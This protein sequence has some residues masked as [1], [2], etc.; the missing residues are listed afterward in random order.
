MVLENLKPKLVWEI[1]EE[2]IA[3][4]P[5]PS[6]HEEQLR[7]AI[8]NWVQGQAKAN[9][10]DIR[11]K[12]DAV[13]NIFIKLPASRGMES[14]P[15]ILFQA[16]LDMV[17]VTD[18][19]G[20]F[21]FDTNPIP[22]R[23]QDNNE[24]VDADG[25]SLGADNGIGVALALAL[26]FEVN[27][28]MKHGPI[29]VL[30]TVDEEAGMSGVRELDVEALEIESKLL[31]NNDTDC[32]GEIYIGCSGGSETTFTKKLERIKDFSEQDYKFVEISISGLLGGHSG[33]E[34]HLPRANA[35]KLMARCLSAGNET[36]DLCL[37]EWNGG[38]KMN[39]IPRVAK[40][41]IAVPADNFGAFQRTFNSEVELIMNYWQYPSEHVEKLEPSLKIELKD[42]KSEPFFYKDETKAIIST[43][44]MVFNGVVNFSPTIEGLTE[45]SNNF[46]IV[47]TTENEIS[48]HFYSRGNHDLK[49]FI[50]SLV[51]LG[52]YTNWE[53]V[54]HEVN[55]GW[56]PDFDSPFLKFVKEHYEKVYQKP[57]IVTAI[58]GGL[59][60]REFIKKIPG[61]QMVSFGPTILRLHSPD[62]KLRIAD[63]GIIFRVI[64]E[65]VTNIDK[66]K[67][68]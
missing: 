42:A 46:A 31:V 12:E 22:I 24:W 16:H 43:A 20:G 48:F 13:G 5:H 29:E 51:Q 40:A 8:K 36:T 18:R 58:H 49:A 59:E 11:M 10:L 26:L 19:P 34:I 3:K 57:I 9:G 67:S 33:G 21:N 25:T 44:D 37:C 64:K 66:Y 45:T 56:I 6:K 50:R 27:G 39:A 2:L 61:I 38:D 30:L 55:F 14:S 35:N 62:E 32:L 68:K 23:I 1:F 53:I 28:D 7:D 52:K 54:K 17:C 63:V 15:A 60:T 41:K 47:N 65:L 4:N